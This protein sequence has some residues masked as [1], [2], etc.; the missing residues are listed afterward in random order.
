MQL[1]SKQVVIVLRQ[2]DWLGTTQ[3][4]QCFKKKI[5]IVAMYEVK[6]I[7]TQPKKI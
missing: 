7:N 1:S 4:S 3:K 2:T 5:G 6:S